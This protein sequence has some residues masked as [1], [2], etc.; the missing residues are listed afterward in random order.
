MDE[1]KI[2]IT[3]FFKSFLSGSVLEFSYF[4]TIEDGAAEYLGKHGGECLRLNGLT[5]LSDAAAEYLSGYGGV[6]ELNGLTSLSDAAA[7]YLSTNY[8]DFLKLNGLTSLSDVAAEHLSTFEGNLELYGLTSLSDANAAKLYRAS[9]DLTKLPNWL[10]ILRTYPG[11]LAD[12][13]KPNQGGW[14]EIHFLRCTCS[15]CGKSRELQTL[16]FNDPEVNHVASLEGQGW[17]GSWQ[18]TFCACPDC[19]LKGENAN[20][21]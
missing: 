21:E 12:A 5:S 10:P 14:E 17:L 18:G 2:L 9:V 20:K 16:F 19:I 6:L 13:S 15:L 1:T 3:E 11:E 7:E 4:T 8:R